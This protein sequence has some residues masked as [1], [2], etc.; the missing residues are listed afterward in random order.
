M[1][2]FVLL[3]F[4][5]SISGSILALLLFALKPFIKHRVSKFAQYLIWIV[6]LLRL[7]LP[8]SFGESIIQDLL[9]DDISPVVITTTQTQEGTGFI[10]T[11]PE[12]QENG[13]TGT[14]NKAIFSES[15]LSSFI[16]QY[17]LY[18]WIIGVLVALTFNL[19]GYLRFSKYLRRANIPA[20][21]EENRILELIL[22]GQKN[23]SLVRNPYATTPMLVGFLRPCIIIPNSAYNEKQLKYI[24]L[25]EIT[26]L[27]RKDIA[28][29]WITMLAT[30]IHWFNPLMYFIKREINYI[31]ELACDETVI[32]KLN[33]TEKQAYGDTL[34]AVVANNKYPVGLLQATMSEEKNTLKERLISIMK[35]SKKSTPLII[36]SVILLVAVIGGALALGAS[37]GKINDGMMYGEALYENE[38]GFSLKLPKEF[39]ED[40]QII[41]EGEIVYFVNK[42]IQANSPEMIFGVVGRIEIYSKNEFT[43][44][45]LAEMDDI[46]GLKYLG[47]NDQYYFG[48]AHATDVQLMPDSSEQL[49]ERFWA[50]EEE[51]NQIL[52]SFTVSQGKSSESC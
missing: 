48:S 12:G 15:T 41:E 46:Y 18:L 25:H 40:I 23:V 26:H 34:I 16:S 47:E 1:S 42:E 32:E 52:E 7:V 24:L 28:I 33:S 5:L 4:S 38:K 22:N 36:V 10:Y 30:S 17:A 44:D 9:Y 37:N 14:L 50:M 51:F 20:T 27:R 49:K 31:C 8:F 19:T 39:A 13:I 45:N 3:I 11:L 2:E 6:V 29:K 43:R 35:H 21:D